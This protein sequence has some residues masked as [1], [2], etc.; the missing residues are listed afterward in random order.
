MDK[1]SMLGATSKAHGLGCGPE[2][3]AVY[4]LVVVG[5]GAGGMAAAVVAACKGLSVAVCEKAPVFGGTT[6]LS[7]GGTWVPCNH[8]AQ[9]AGVSD[10][11]QQ[12]LDYFRSCVGERLNEPMA[13]RFIDQA[14]RM[15]AYLEEHTLAKFSY[16]AGRPDYRPQ[17]PG[18]ATQGRTVHPLPFDGRQ[19]GAQI[20]RLRPPLR[21]MTFLGMMIKPGPE[22]K[23]FLNVLRS[24]ESA[25]YVTRKVLRHLRD[26]LVYRRGMD[27]SNGNALI[28][29]LARSGFDHG[30]DIFTGTPVRHLVIDEDRVC[31]VVVERKGRRLTLK[32]RRGVV[33]ATGGFSHDPE[34]RKAH[35]PHAARSQ[36]HWSPVP[37]TVEGDGLRLGE[38]AGGHVQEGQAHAACWAPVSRVPQ[39]GGGFTV[40]PHLIDRQKPGFIAVTRRGY[41]F[42]N[43]ANSYH[44]FGQAMISACSQEDQVTVFLIADHR[45]IR[46]YGM[47][48][49]KPAPVPIGD[50]IRSGY[51]LRARTLEELATSA[52]ID[53]GAFIRTVSEFNAHARRGE[54]PA[55]G[56]GGN[57]YNRY[58]GD[59]GHEPNPCLA[60]IENGPFY[61][62]KLHIGELATLT[63]MAI[64][65]DARVL[66]AQGD[67]VAGL[68]ACGN[69]ASNVMGGDYLGG[70][71][72]LGPGMTFGYLAACHA[73]GQAD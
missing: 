22:L 67:P 39:P 65:P 8:L 41:R 58:N 68:Y 30:I 40:I 10:S 43:E 1:A 51:L 37:S 45:A 31:G 19:L 55:F 63:G 42:V 56:K 50:H 49:V 32:A 6:A 17:A 47:G 44:D 12:A 46:R 28:A 3:G 38:E 15:L 26:L 23:H 60:P 21:E 36:A 66:T 27:L 24:F 14:P 48:A 29:R 72:T 62:V 35:F 57:I 61:A 20:E 64:D 70:G 7:A 52:G 54:D 18:A 9:A 73:A 5:S 11:A 16:A 34:R 4:D 25:R 71:A 33:L 59:P 53:I 13:R 2:D 69:D